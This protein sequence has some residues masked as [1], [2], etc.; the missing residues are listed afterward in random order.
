MVRIVH[1]SKVNYWGPKMRNRGFTLIE[2]MIVL[3][4][5]G[6][7]LAIAIPAYNDFTIRAR[8][9]EGYAVAAQAKTG[10]SEFRFTENR[11]PNSNSQSGFTETIQSP[12]VESVKVQP[13]G[14]RIVITYRNIGDG[15]AGT[16]I[17]LIPTLVNRGVLNWTCRPGQTNPIS[18]RYVAGACR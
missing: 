5:L 9:G 6:I 13:T 18:P 7:L 3:A 11:W 8:V 15:V 2:L 10:V 1:V 14:G 17:D 4:I 12:Y 16:T